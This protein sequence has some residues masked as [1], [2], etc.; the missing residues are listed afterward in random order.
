MISTS[1]KAKISILVD[2]TKD[3]NDSYP[4]LLKDPLKMLKQTKN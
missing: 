4:K 3:M 2:K 1:I